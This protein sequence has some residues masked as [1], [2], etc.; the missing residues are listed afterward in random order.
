M[1]KSF[2]NIENSIYNNTLND[3]WGGV[4]HALKRYRICNLAIL[5]TKLH[6]EGNIVEIG[7]ARG[8]CSKLISENINEKFN[9]HLFDTFEGLPPATE[10][11][12][13]TNNL[14]N[15]ICFSLDYVK[16]FIGNKKNVF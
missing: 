1:Y 10:K 15:A 11:D 7:V 8:D 14:E 4:G 2:Y 5:L 3:V 6:Q 16:N 9:V 12:L 13:L